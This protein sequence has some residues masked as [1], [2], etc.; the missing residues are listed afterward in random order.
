ML[1][2]E[3]KKL[4]AGSVVPASRGVGFEGDLNLSYKACL[5][6]RT[7]SRLLLE[8]FSDK[9]GNED[10]LYR[11]ALNHPWEELFSPSMSISCR[12]TG[13]PRDKDPRYA[14]LKLKDAIVDRFMEKSGSRPFVE[15]K[16]PD[17]RI[18][19]RW[20]GRQAVIYL[21][22]SGQPLHERGYRLERTDA[23]L[24]E[25]TAAAILAIAGW[26]RIAQDGGG[27]VDPVCGSGT[28]LIEAAMMAIDAPPGIHRKIWGFEGLSLHD[29]NL[30]RKI[31][32][33]ASIRYGGSLERMPLLAGFDIN[34]TALRVA[35]SNL[36][37]AGL[38]NVVRLER[39][40]ITQGR[41]SFWP[42]GNMGLV[43]A[44]PP[45]GVRIPTDPLPV[46]KSLGSLFRTLE[47]GW[48]LA[49]L[50]PDRKTASVTC[51]RAEEY[52]HTVSGGMDLVLALY[53]RLGAP[54]TGAS[55]TGVP[56][57]T[58]PKSVPESVTSLDPKAASLK[59]S[60]QRNIDAMKSWSEKTGVSSYR[61]WDA[62]M[63]EFN[64]AV[65][66]YEGRWLHVQEFAAPGKI[67]PEK[68]RSRLNTLLSVLKEV[69]GCR[70]EDLYIKTRQRGIRPYSRMGDSRDRFIIRENGMKFYVNFI[71]YLDT[72]IFMDH[73]PT[74]AIIRDRIGRGRFLN[75]FAYTGT[76]SV[77]AAAGGAT[78]TVSVDVSNTYL[79]WARDN[80]KLN[81]LETSSCS[82]VRSD[83][84]EFLK[85]HD[86]KF[87]LIFIDPPTYSNGAGRMD[88][89]V[90][91]HHA[92]LIKLAMKHLN[93]DGTLLFAENFRRFRLDGE[94]NKRFSVREITRETTDPD[95]FR[96]SGAHRC[97][98]F[99]HSR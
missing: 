6:L 25:T 62:D 31:R 74:R 53:D 68:T 60:L 23:V 40:D 8:L 45:Y 59:T 73:R 71:D 16:T 94:L 82:Y 81:R 79:N 55:K 89:S 85:K 24:R 29:D 83:A 42:A 43:C 15:R 37:R 90:Q 92:P 54:K 12:V 9:A 77:M 58:V 3:L 14:T 65:D 57:K 93:Q 11:L 27:F 52:H 22:W 41:P 87:D 33:D 95:F 76:A 86:E 4:H 91:D 5:E 51:L 63:P 96:R 50:A 99:S 39:H 56:V 84:F 1:T 20:D 49:L 38:N 66:W 46:Y 7:A 70:D 98:E 61:I 64:A 32:N 88:W 47:S 44:D 72:G 75:L 30:W 21:N 28:L 69:T 10:E 97:W 17:I 13:V 36:R 26:P 48:R 35:R 18:E 34:E 19:A 67:P 80:M 2:G 78:L